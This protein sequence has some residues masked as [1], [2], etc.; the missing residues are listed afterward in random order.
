[1]KIERLVSETTAIFNSVNAEKLQKEDKQTLT[2]DAVTFDSEKN[3]NS[4]SQYQSPKEE[5]PDLK[6]ETPESNVI[7]L[8]EQKGLG[9]KIDILV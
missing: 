2:T 9:K 8:K 4:R 7:H 1:M 5:S 3:N 6:D